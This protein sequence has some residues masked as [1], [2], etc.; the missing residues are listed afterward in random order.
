MTTAASGA[1]HFTRPRPGWLLRQL[2]AIP[3]LLYRI[4]L[5]KRAG[6]SLMLLTTIGRRSGRP[7]RVGLNYAR[8]GMTVYVLAGFAPCHWYRNVVAHPR[9]IVQIGDERWT[10]DGRPVTDPVE[11]ERARSLLRAA[12]NAQGP[13]RVI[14]P[15]FARLGFDYDAEVRRMDQ[16]GFDLPILAITTPV[17]RQPLPHVS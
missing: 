13:P 1:T 14:R 6:R 9:V 5:A 11:R 2:L 7:R 8:A 16:P 4:G 3:P 10:G 15:V 12:A 17:T